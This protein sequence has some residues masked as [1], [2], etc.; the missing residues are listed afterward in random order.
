MA[1]AAHICG[2]CDFRHVTK[3]SVVWC[4]EC[5][6]GFCSDCEEHH[7]FAKATRNH[8]T[9]PIAEYQKLPQDVLEIPQSCIKHNEKFLLYCRD[10]ETP[11]CGKCVNDG[12]KKCR[13]VVDLD[14]LLKNAK[15]SSSFV[16]VED[17]LS[18]VV[19]NIKKVRK[20]FQEN[21]RTISDNRKSI[22][23]E[24]QEIR[25][26][27]NNHLDQMQKKMMND[28]RTSEENISVEIQQNMKILNEKEQFLM[29]YQKK[30][31]SIKYHAT[32]LQIFMA[33][34]QLENELLVED[35]FLKSYD[36]N[37]RKKIIA[38]KIDA[39]V[40]AIMTNLNRIG[41]IEI[42]TTLCDLSL[43]CKKNAQAQMIIPKVL[44]KSIYNTELKLENKFSTSFESIR[45]CCQ[46]PDGKIVLSCFKTKAVMFLNKDGSEDCVLGLP[47]AV[48][49]AYVKTEN[50]IAVTSYLPQDCIQFIDVSSMK[51]KKSI[52]LNTANMN[53]GIIERQN[54]LVL[55]SESSGLKMLNITDESVSNIIT[56]EMSAFSY[57]DTYDDKFFYTNF[58]QNTVKCCDIE[59]RVAWT[60]KDTNILRT[61]F[62][63]AVD[64]NGDIY[65]IGGDSCNVVVIEPT[66]QHCREL[67]SSKDGLYSPQSIYCERRSNTLLVANGKHN[68]FKYQ[69]VKEEL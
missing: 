36:K 29:T 1:S 32:D 40:E 57:V 18:E 25:L 33:R 44:P 48:S 58:N 8:N 31:S 7:S 13:E 45:G 10:H 66:G 68:V 55:C 17:T 42:E 26:K 6:E 54:M 49:V 35:A 34:K 9:I 5:D 69:I 63:I 12:H 50:T 19:D 43:A 38:L 23:K 59:G 20:F 37:A 53:Y 46:L 47:S 41:K 52:S 2:V 39:A 4:P 27:V 51:V 15:T 30:I 16:E 14:D 3:P 22:E 21:L 60:F 11:C 62:G 28:V 65:V 64:N 24:V 61:P 67:L 56:D